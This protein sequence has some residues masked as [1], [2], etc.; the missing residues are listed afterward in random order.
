M[1]LRPVRT[2]HQP[3]PQRRR[4]PATLQQNTPIRRPGRFTATASHTNR[5]APTR[6]R[7]PPRRARGDPLVAP[8]R[9]TPLCP[10]RHPHRKSQA[11]SARSTGRCRSVASP[12]PPPGATPQYAAVRMRLRRRGTGLQ[13]GISAYRHGNRGGPIVVEVMPCQHAPPPAGRHA[14]PLTVTPRRTP[15]GR[16]RRGEPGSC[17]KDIGRIAAT[18]DAPLPPLKPPFVR[19]LHRPPPQR[20]SRPPRAVRSPQHAAVRAPLRRRGNG[21]LPGLA[22]YRRCTGEAL[23]PPKEL[24]SRTFQ[25]TMGRNKG[26]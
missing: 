4:P 7:W 18:P 13:R 19:T 23:S 1:K 20:H 6:R 16:S 17:R 24:R 26:A 9:S 2:P 21:R 15:P 8:C 10:T 14:P 12:Q 5:H 25:P 3:L 22:A 11:P